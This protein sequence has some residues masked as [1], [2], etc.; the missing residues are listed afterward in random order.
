MLGW[1]VVTFN[2]HIALTRHLS[3][4]LCAVLVVLTMTEHVGLASSERIMFGSQST[5]VDHS[6]LHRA[7][8]SPLSS[9]SHPASCCHDAGCPLGSCHHAVMTETKLTQPARSSFF[10]TKTMTVGVPVFGTPYPPPK[11]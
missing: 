5:P 3:K 7:T 9:P 6:A 11:K 4:W 1:S 2:L 10:A 8:D